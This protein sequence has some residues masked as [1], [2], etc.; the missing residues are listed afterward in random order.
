[1]PSP[2]DIQ[3]AALRSFRSKIIGHPHINHARDRLRLLMREGSGVSISLLAGPSRAGKTT[4][5]DKVLADHLQARMEKMRADPSYCPI[6]Y[7]RAASSRRGVFDSSDLYT[8]ALEQLN[9]PGLDRKEEARAT[10]GGTEIRWTR[11]GH[12]SSALR[13]LLVKA[14]RHRRTEVV[15]VDESQHIARVAGDERLKDSMDDLKFIAEETGVFILL[16]G[17]YGVLDCAEL[18][19][20]IASRGASVHLPRYR[21]VIEADV[22][23]F[24]V[25]LNTL[26]KALPIPLS[27]S[28]AQDWLYFYKKTA[29]VIG[30]LKLLLGNALAEAQARGADCISKKDLDVVTLAPSALVRIVTEINEGEA[31]WDK[32]AAQEPE[33]ERLLGLNL[34][35]EEPDAAGTPGTKPSKRR[36][37]VRAPVRDPVGV[38]P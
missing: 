23:A 19:A 18:N 5:L 29:G 22:H 36:V 24:K 8:R 28:L 14:L 11:V 34:L 32:A 27:G 9:E 16:A 17:G 10:D 38:L 13:R 21:V 37:G 35:E 33:L 25:L 4:L 20:Q 12:S 30:L 15:L 2:D 3:V 6:I 26:I 7:V 31:R 1:M